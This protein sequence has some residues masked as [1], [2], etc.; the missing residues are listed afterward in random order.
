VLLASSAKQ[1][2]RVRSGRDDKGKGRYGPQQTFRDRQTQ[3]SPLR[4]APVEMT[5]GWVVMARSCGLGIGKTQISPLRFA[6]VEMT[7]GWVVMARNRGLGIDK[8][9]SLHCASLRSR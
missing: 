9:R 7:K 4:F 6:P 5:K 8:R 1:E 2:I 3:I